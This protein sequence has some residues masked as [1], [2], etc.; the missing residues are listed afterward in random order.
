M[1]SVQGPR[2]VARTRTRVAAACALAALGGAAAAAVHASASPDARARGLALVQL[3]V[4]VRL[5]DHGCTV[6]VEAR[7]RSVTFRIANRG[8]VRLAFAI[9]GRRTTVRPAGSA[10]LAVHFPR[11]GSY[12][13]RCSR[14]GLSPQ[15]G[16]LRIVETSGG[17]PTAAA[18]CGASGPPPTTYQHVV[19]VV[20]ENKSY[21]QVMGSTNAPNLN[22]LAEACG[23]AANFYAEGHPSLPNYIAMTS[24][25]TQGITNDAGPDSHPLRVDNIFQQVED[26]RSLEESMPSNCSL[27]DTSY[28]AVRHNPAAYYVGIRPA[29]ATRD[30]PLGGTPDLSA[31]FTFVTPNTCHDMHAS[32]CANSAADEVRQGDTW[33]G[34]FLASVFETKQYRAG[35][36]VVFVTWDEDDYGASDA[37]HVP[38]LVFAPSVRRG[39]VSNVRFDHYSLLRTTEELLGLHTFLGGAATAAGMR[40]AFHL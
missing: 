32:P 35:T 23:L 26:W 22:R 14:R 37:E 34:T 10:R 17:G 4:S 2:L 39:T 12:D 36:T 24:G 16:R 5:T 40:S 25:S 7:S 21:S 6:P 19:W 31:R 30:V 28:Y 29:C 1:P 11:A 13:Y 18:P 27:S 9:A 8:H 38:T 15:H 33:L 3:Q 20:L